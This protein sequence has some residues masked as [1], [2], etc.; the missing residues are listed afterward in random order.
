MSKIKVTLKKDLT[1]TLSGINYRDLRS[2]FTQAS[3][4]SHDSLKRAQKDYETVL[5]GENLEYEDMSE[6]LREQLHDVRVRNAKGD[7]TYCEHMLG[8]SH[9]LGELIKDA[10]QNEN[11]RKR[12]VA[13]SEEDQIFVRQRASGEKIAYMV[14]KNTYPLPPDCYTKQ[15]A[16]GALGCYT[17]LEEA[18]KAHPDLDLS[19]NL[20]VACRTFGNWELGE[21]IE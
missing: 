19:T 3:L 15:V 21:K 8:L 17:S 13:E 9:L 14:P 11:N 6:S 18:T 16:D 20:K 10:T 1:V 5:R 12:A 7:V 2:L 4:Y